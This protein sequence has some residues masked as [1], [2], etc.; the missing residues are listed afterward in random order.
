MN[1]FAILQVD[2]ENATIESIE[3]VAF[4]T[5]T[6][7]SSKPKLSLD[8]VEDAASVVKN[9]SKALSKTFEV[10]SLTYLK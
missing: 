10:C 5:F 6:F 2:P 7:T 8:E 3:K 1:L 4:F 9:I